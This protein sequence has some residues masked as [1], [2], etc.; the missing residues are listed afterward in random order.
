MNRRSSGILLHL[1]SLPSRFGIGDLG[2][3]AYKFADF[4]SE[5]G[6]RLWQI[7]PV[8]PPRP[9]HYSP[10][11]SP[12]AFAGNP[13][14]ISPELLVYEGLLDESDVQGSFEFPPDRVDF[15][16][17]VAFK[18]GVLERAYRSFARNGKPAEYE[19]FCT[20]SAYW[21]DDFALFVALEERYD[22]HV[23][24]QWPE[25]LRDRRPESLLRAKEDHRE[26]IERAKF[27]Q[28]IFYRQWKAFRDYCNG[29]GVRIFGDI[30]I[31]V[32]FNSADVWTHPHMFKLDDQKSPLV[33][34]GVPPD[35]FSETG[36]LW[37]HPIYRWDALEETGY[38]W[39]MERI[40]HNLKL[41]DLVRIDHFRGFV[42]HWEVPAGEKTAMHGK[43]T[44]GP[45]SHF[46]RAVFD[47]FPE[48]PIIAED[49]GVIT[50]DVVEVMEEFDFPGMKI[51]LFAFGDDPATN[52]YIPHN[53]VRNCV[54]YT[55]T[56]D[57][58]TARGW[59][60]DEISEEERRRVLNYIGREVPPAEIHWELVRMVMMSVADT[61]VFPLQ[62]VLGL[63]SEDR[64]NMP[65]VPNGNWRWRLRPEM[66]TDELRSRL[67]AMTQT[68]GRAAALR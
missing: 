10:Y 22:G 61:A 60:E 9:D 40:G 3:S 54:A 41:C 30:P 33:V 53:L 12:S 45:G 63:G 8:N 31:Y 66:L 65:S 36:Q 28:Y 58:N 52:P 43:W 2:P 16:A 19:Q 5:T 23:W 39:W 57:N 26:T 1:T 64:M 14:L 46:F 18:N 27:F 47:R 42:G 7:L 13:L 15:P 37:G 49:L 38:E 67:L 62:D 6:Q 48:L 24:N 25:D 35:Y 56:H 32:D 51:L 4:L 17:A 29:N 59:F 11:Q 21:L 34:S 44:A 68:Y 20:E 50:P 55:G